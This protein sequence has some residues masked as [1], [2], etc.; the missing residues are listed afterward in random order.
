MKKIRNDEREMPRDFAK[1]INMWSF[2]S[3]GAIIFDRRFNLFD[4][5]IKNEK[6]KTLIHYVRYAAEEVIKFEADFT[7]WKYYHTHEF[8]NLMDISNNIV[9]YE[10]INYYFCKMSLILPITVSCC[11]L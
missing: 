11:P 10:R 3:L 4:E 9:E 6:A 5:N 2:E 8:K 1:Y 7:I